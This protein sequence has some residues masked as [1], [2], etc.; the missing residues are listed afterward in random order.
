LFYC[1]RGRRHRGANFTERGDHRRPGREKTGVVKLLFASIVVAERN[2]HNPS[3]QILPLLTPPGRG[4]NSV[5][6][7][8]HF[9]RPASASPCQAGPDVAN[10]APHCKK[11]YPTILGAPPTSE[12]T[13]ARVRRPRMALAADAP[14]RVAFL[15]TQGTAP[16]DDRP[17]GLDRFRKSPYA[18]RVFG[19]FSICLRIS[20]AQRLSFPLF[21]KITVNS[22]SAKMRLRLPRAQGCR[23]VGPP[24]G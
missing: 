5:R 3:P 10:P 11:A 1:R 23:F 20:P 6:P 14:P 4:L 16:L 15:G 22:R 13:A 21:S 12:K 18:A 7:R 9:R 2:P 24:A 17:A 8:A 19:Y